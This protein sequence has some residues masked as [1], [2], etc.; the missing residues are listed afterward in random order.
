MQAVRRPSHAIQARGH[1][2]QRFDAKTLEQH[3]KQ[4]RDRAEQDTV[5]FSL[6]DVV[7][8]EIVEV[9]AE[10]VEQAIGN[11]GKAV[12]EQHFLE[13]PPGQLRHF[14]KQHDDESERE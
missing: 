11:Q 4:R 13:A 12:E 5:E 10:H 7:V 9:Q 3:L 2:L 14:L 1:F 8:A 6:D